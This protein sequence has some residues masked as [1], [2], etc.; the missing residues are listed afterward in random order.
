M[1]AAAK[2]SKIT[3]RIEE[4]SEVEAQ[5][6]LRDAQAK[7]DEII[8]QAKAEA[9]SVEDEIIQKG[10]HDAELI[11][12][13]IIANAKLR[14]KKHGLD[15]KEKIIQ[16]AFDEAEKRLE[17]ITLSKEYQN[18]LKSIIAEGVESI[19][20]DDV[21]VVV[22]KEDVKLVNKAFLK[23]LRK[24]L[25]VNIT[26]SEDSIKSLGGAIIRTRDGTIVVNNT[27]ETRMRRMRDELRSKVAKI[28]FEE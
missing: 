1:N 19:G 13:R 6:I 21:E 10:R 20:G 15:V 3:S 23:E 7:A 12:Q 2:A 26:L 17:K 18:I 22:R 4:D 24:K 5:E 11:N 14:A 28:L 25:G 27:F 9:K 16:N 8:A